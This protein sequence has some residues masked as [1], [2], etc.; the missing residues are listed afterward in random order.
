MP[1]RNILKDDVADCYYHVYAR[2]VNKEKIFKDSADFSFFLS[3]LSRY[4]SPSDTSTYR[5]LAYAKLHA[6]MELLAYCLMQN[7]FHLLVYQI[8]Q[9]TM[10][11][12]MRGVMTSYSHYF[13]T[14]YERTGP[15]FETRYRA[16]RIQDDSYLLHIS[17]YIHLN[18]LDWRRYEYS[19]FGSYTNAHRPDWLMPAKIQSLFGTAEAYIQFIQDYEERRDELE[20]LKHALAN[21]T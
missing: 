4:L 8:D 21:D 9:G 20:V 14:K 13:N 7:H 3:L 19:S 15:L 16:S 18:P 10:T 2:G 5:G 6:S 12:L 11:R 17:R 1:G